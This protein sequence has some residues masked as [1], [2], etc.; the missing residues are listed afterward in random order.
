MP[1]SFGGT[2]S[3]IAA[4]S[5][6]LTS[7]GVESQVLSLGVTRKTF[8]HAGINHINVKRD[9]SL[10]Q[11]D[12]SINLFSALRKAAK[13]ADLIHC[14]Y[15]WP[16]GDA[17]MLGTNK[18]YIITYHS[19]IIRQKAIKPLYAPL[20]KHFLRRAKA[21]IST[22]PQYAGSSKNL[23][24]HAQKTHIIPFGITD[25]YEE[26]KQTA[27]YFLFIGNL[28]YYKGLDVLIKAASSTPYPIYIL[29]IGQEEARLKALAG[30]LNAKNVHFLG[31][32]NEQEKW[33]ILKN[34][35]AFI[36]PSLMRSEAFGIALLE[37]AMM[38]KAMISTR[39]NTGT[40]LINQHDITGHEVEAG[41]VDALKN[42]LKTFTMHPEK[43]KIYGENARK[44]YLE[45]F[46]LQKMLLAYKNIYQDVLKR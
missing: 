35:Y 25:R 29:G 36:F 12:M 14:H 40:S 21:I 34:A 32:V 1:T 18:P 23:Q 9:F 4:L 10:F 22:S 31:G 44:H 6:G 30:A 2:E 45:H 16:F 17:A 8:A 11:N 19:D 37:A 41:N 38:G 24:A 15:P 39:L 20:E 46:S 7:H 27:P 43:V 3:F 26:P 5:E 13:E 28:R 42:A 33:Q